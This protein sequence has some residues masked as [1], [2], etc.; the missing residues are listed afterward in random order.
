MLFVNFAVVNAFQLERIF[1]SNKKLGTRIELNVA[2]IMKPSL[3]LH[4]DITVCQK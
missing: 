4:Y 3:I 1:H 2:A